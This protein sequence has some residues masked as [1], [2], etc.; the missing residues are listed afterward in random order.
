SNQGFTSFD[1]ISI[2]FSFLILITIIVP[3]LGRRVDTQYAEVAKRQAE[4]L[5]QKISS[6]ENLSDDSDGRAPASEASLLGGVISADPWGQPYRYQ[7]ARNSSGQPVYV[8]VWSSGPNEKSETEE[9]K[10]AV[11]PEGFL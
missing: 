3:I 10:I 5:S 9:S 2:V 8:V 1:A 11:S 4:E 6:L 7:Y